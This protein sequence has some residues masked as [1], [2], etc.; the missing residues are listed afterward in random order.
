MAPS[1]MRF[2]LLVRLAWELRAV[3]VSCWLVLRGDGEPVLFVRDEDGDRRAVLVGECH[4]SW[5]VM[6]CGEELGTAQLD[7]T[8][9]TIA[10]GLAA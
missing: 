6:W 3:P 4:D 9:R 7:V 2:A 10:K 5:R 1:E 8:A